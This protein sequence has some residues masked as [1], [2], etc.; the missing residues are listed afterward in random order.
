MKMI[1]VKEAIPTQVD[2][3]KGANY[4][5]T[6]CALLFFATTINYIDR[7]VLGILAP[8][9]EKEIGWSES[10][11]GFIVTALQGAYGIGLLAVCRMMDVLGTKIGYSVAMVLWSLGAME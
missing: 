3:P 2:R 1:A 9:L 4:R 8:V 10:Q 5:W 6:V 7:Q 11:Y